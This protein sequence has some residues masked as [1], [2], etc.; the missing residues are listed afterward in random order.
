MS[1]YRLPQR[2][3]LEAFLAQ[4]G[5]PLPKQLEILGDGVSN[6][7]LK[8]VTSR[9]PLVLTLFEWFPLEQ[10]KPVLR[11][12]FSLHQ[13]CFPCP[14]PVEDKQGRILTKMDGRPAALFEWIED[15]GH[16]LPTP[17]SVGKLLGHLH[18]LGLELPLDRPNP[19]GAQWLAETALSL[20]DRL[21][22]SDR[23]L[24]DE[25]LEYLSRHRQMQ[26]PS[27]SIHGDL[28]ADN[29]RVVDGEIRGLIDFEFAG[30]EVLLFDVAVAINAFCSLEDGRLDRVAM[31]D[32]LE[33]YTTWRP[34]N[35]EENLAIPMML[36]AAALRFWVSRLQEAQQP[37]EGEA[38]L[39]KPADEFRRILLQRRNRLSGMQ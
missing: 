18:R 25:E 38:V 15:D 16:S 12:Q 34:L 36:R 21:S 33:G 8:L 10:M 27:G 29:L 3:D 5:L 9:R 30:H 2:D 19:R 4:H 26:L 14:A 39:R 1:V 28:F 20:R 11:W 37:V 23:D 17:S 7:N 31:R 32:L 6:T 22:P 24:L 35:H 13:A